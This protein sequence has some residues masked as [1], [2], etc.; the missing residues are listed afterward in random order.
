MCLNES[1][2]PKVGIGI[3]LYFGTSGLFELLA[4]KNSKA[5]S[6]HAYFD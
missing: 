1:K 6:V 5:L 2:K 3:F 4:F